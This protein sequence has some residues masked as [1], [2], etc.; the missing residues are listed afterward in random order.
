M[1]WFVTFAIVIWLLCGVAGA[2]ML[3]AGGDLRW[4]AIARGPITLVKAYNESS[5]SYP[6]GT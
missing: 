1:K 5:G 4:K 3:G 6:D 2:W